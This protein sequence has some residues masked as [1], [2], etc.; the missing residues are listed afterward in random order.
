MLLRLELVDECYV[1]WG[2]AL[3]KFKEECVSIVKR[4]AAVRDALELKLDD[5]AKMDALSAEVRKMV[6]FVQSWPVRQS[7]M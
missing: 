3:Q 1:F 2:R 5:Q 6:I 7:N 4:N